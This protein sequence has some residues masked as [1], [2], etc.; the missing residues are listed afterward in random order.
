MPTLWSND[1]RIVR[2]KAEKA[3]ELSGDWCFDASVFLFLA[4]LL[5][6]QQEFPTFYHESNGGKLKPR[7]QC[8][9]ESV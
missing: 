5:T 1:S 3:T 4:A 2:C 6:Y 7:K 8:A 9:G